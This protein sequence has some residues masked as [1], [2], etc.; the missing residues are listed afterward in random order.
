[1]LFKYK[2]YEQNGKKV[3]GKI[4]ASDIDQAKAKLK[5]KK[6]LVNFLE[7]V[8]IPFLERFKF[9]SRSKIEPEVLSNISKT[10]S[11]YLDSGISLLNGVK[12][13]QESYKENKKMLTFFESIIALLDE[14]KNFYTALES[15]KTLIIPEF[16]LQSVK[17][18]EDGG[19][20]QGV[21]LELSVYIDEQQKIKKEISS[22]MIYPFIIIG[23]SILVV[24]FMLSFVVPKITSIFEQNEQKLPWITEFVIKS[25]D[26]L[27]NNFIIISMIIFTLVLLYNFLVKRFYRFRYAKDKLKLKVPFF[28]QVIHMNELSRFSYMNSILLKSGVTVVQAFKMG[29]NILDNSVL[30]SIFEKASKKVVEGEKLSRILDTNGEY[31]IDR[32]FIQAIAIGEETSELNRVLQNIA[33]LYNDKS[34]DKMGK[35]LQILQPM[36]ILMV[37]LSIGIIVVAM[38]LPIFSM[39]IG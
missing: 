34:K 23:V 37:A 14:G 11:I 31:K 29:A 15:Q 10:L 30:K 26:F 9:E 32:A 7:E 25:G 36:L 1:M 24:A 22:A 5:Q 17:I 39:S 12:L 8:S 18:S 3:S 6:L 27:S 13:I 21:L 20:L 35:F 16:Y 33:T 38:L 19:I 28:G 4:E 2:G